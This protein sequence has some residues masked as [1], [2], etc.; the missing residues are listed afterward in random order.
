M[1][2]ISRQSMR[3]LGGLAVCCVLGFAVACSDSNNTQPTGDAAAVEAAPPAGEAAPAAEDAAP[4]ADEA[5]A[6]GEPEEA[7]APEE[8]AAPGETAPP[9]AAPNS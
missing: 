3:V 2:R 8:G 7:P 9:E 4:A 5:G 1:S 6:A